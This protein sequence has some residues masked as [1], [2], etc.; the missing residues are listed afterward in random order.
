MSVTT[1]AIATE[2]VTGDGVRLHVET[3]GPAD[4]PVTVLLAHGWT[5]STRSWHHQLGALPG[6]LGSGA[7]VVAYDQRGHGRSGSAGSCTTMAH[8]ARDLVDVIGAVAPEGPIVYAGHSM[9]GMALME[10]TALR[11]DIVRDRFAGITFVSTSAGQLASRPFGLAAGFDRA[12]SLIAPR[13]VGAAGRRADRR[14]LRHPSTRAGQAGRPLT[15]SRVQRPAIRLAAFGRHV[16]PAEV[17]ILTADV[18]R[19]P[20]TS[21][22]GF[23]TAIT[24]HDRTDALAALDGIPVEVM[25]GTRDRLLPPRHANRLAGLVPGARLWMYPGAGHMLPQERPRDVTSRIAAQARR[26]LM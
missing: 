2:V 6:L 9:G 21:L 16:D 7:R 4:A 13:A 14:A 24:E 19:T 12:A 20:G 18:A 11:P 23:F 3:A 15:V 17:D 25:H 26:A 8:L 10:L 5:C 22:A 1:Q